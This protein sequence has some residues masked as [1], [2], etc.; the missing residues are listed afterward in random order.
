MH[1]FEIQT[2]VVALS[3]S[4]RFSGHFPG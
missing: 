1:S 2:Y 4:L 3:L